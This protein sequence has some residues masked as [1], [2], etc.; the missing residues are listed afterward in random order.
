MNLFAQKPTIH[1]YPQN[2]GDLKVQKS[3]EK[4]VVTL[5]IGS[6]R[7]K[8]TILHDGGGSLY[9][10]EQLRTLTPNRCTYGYDVLVYVGRALSLENRN[11]KQIIED[12]RR[13]N[14][15]ISPRQIGVLGKKFIVY[16]AL[17]H[18]QSRERL[19]QAMVSRGGYILH[20]DGT[21]EGDSPHLFTG[22]D[23]IAQIVW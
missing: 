21:C 23:G 1:F 17:A 5:D 15:L 16:L 14:V 6:F 7:A 12:L 2:S 20:L 11:E 3:R 13:K 8:E 19:K 4:N 18:Q 9:H 10:S 22:I